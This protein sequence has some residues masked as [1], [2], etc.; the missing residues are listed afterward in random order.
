MASP[1]TARQI[2]AADGTRWLHTLHG[3]EH[4]RPDVTCVHLVIQDE[5]GTLELE[6]VGGRVSMDL[7]EIPTRVLFVLLAPMAG[8][9]GDFVSD[10]E[11]LRRVIP[12]RA[13][14]FAASRGVEVSIRYP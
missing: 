13:T 12:A 8:R 7:S 9:P 4:A 3:G 1:S 6:F 5:G 14:R 10:L 2:L 11:L